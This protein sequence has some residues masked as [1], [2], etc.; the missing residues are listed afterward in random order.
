MLHGVSQPVDELLVDNQPVNLHPAD[1]RISIW[2]RLF[3]NKQA[4]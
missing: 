4:Q 1:W 2:L 3:Y